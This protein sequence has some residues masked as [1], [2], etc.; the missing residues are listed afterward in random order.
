MASPSSPAPEVRISAL[1]SSGSPVKRANNHPSCV[2]N[3]HGIPAFTLPV[4]E[5]FYLRCPPRFQNFKFW[6]LL[7]CRSVLILR[8]RVLLCFCLLLASARKTVAQPLSSS[9]FMVERE[10][11]G[12]QALCPQLESPLLCLETMPPILLVTQGIL[13]PQYP[14]LGLCLTSPPEHL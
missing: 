3:F 14:L 2:P 7:W 8:G 5:L 4:S 13:R 11:A 6:R 12:T 10:R 1:Q 9:E